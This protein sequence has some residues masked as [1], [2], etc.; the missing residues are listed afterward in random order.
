[1]VQDKHNVVP[2]SMAVLLHVV[3]FGSL[4]MVF[5]FGRPDRLEIPLAIKGTLVTDNAVVIPPQVEEP[6]E[7]REPPP[8]EEP[9]PPEP[10]TS[11]QERRA[12]E[13]QKRLEDA[14]VERERLERLEQIREQQA[15]KKRIAEEAEQK[16][17]AE[18]A[19][20]KR[21]VEEERQKREAE[22]E[23]ERKRVEAERQRQE[24]IERQRL[25]NER[26][27][28]EA[29]AA[30]RQQELDT[31]ANRMAAA[32]ADAKAAYMFAIRQK[33]ARNW[34][35]P[36]SA[37]VGLECT[38]NVRQLPGGEVIDVSIGRCNGDETVRR[39]IESAVFKASPLP[40]PRDPGVFDRDLT[41]IF[42]PT[43]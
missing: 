15:E 8:A 5:D 29:E 16:R 18:E 32:T 4:L 31:E 30:A 3:L 11:E 2:V 7:V 13:E 21:I 26:L 43:D 27:R 41:L 6:P 17:L 10:D 23:M 20:R 25:E 34:V 37:E 40:A 24:E 36:A 38:V 28:R 19:E 39:S 1:M 35:R 14:R 9:P 33:I 42:K 12:A 22:A